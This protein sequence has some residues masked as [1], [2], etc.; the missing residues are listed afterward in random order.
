M[1]MGAAT[2]HARSCKVQGE[3]SP[4]SL[5]GH[6]SVTNGRGEIEVVKNSSLPHVPVDEDCSMTPRSSPF[7]WGPLGRPRNTKGTHW[8]RRRAVILAQRQSTFSGTCGQWPLRLEYRARAGSESRTRSVGSGQ[9]EWEGIGRAEREGRISVAEVFSWDL[10]LASKCLPASRRQK[11][12]QPV[13]QMDKRILI[14][15]SWEKHEGLWSV[16]TWG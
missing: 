3:F 10:E 1:S 11:D 16:V 9:R 7:A 4:A 14:I 15:T 5:Q 8:V 6:F 2:R 13:E 12:P